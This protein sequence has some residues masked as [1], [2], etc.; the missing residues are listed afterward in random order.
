MLFSLA[1]KTLYFATFL[2][3]FRTFNRQLV[4]T[5]VCIPEVLPIGFRSALACEKSINK[6]QL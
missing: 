2:T 1:G 4:C 5:L 6:L 3:K